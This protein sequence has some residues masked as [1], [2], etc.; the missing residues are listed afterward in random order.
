MLYYIKHQKMYKS[1]RALRDVIGE[2][3]YDWEFAHHNII[4]I[5][6]NEFLDKIKDIDLFD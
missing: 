5:N 2:G 6:D 4:F 1:R 3:R